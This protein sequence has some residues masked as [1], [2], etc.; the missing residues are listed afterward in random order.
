[1]FDFTYIYFHLIYFFFKRAKKKY[2]WNKTAD[3]TFI[4]VVISNDI[5]DIGNLED[6]L[7]KKC[8][9]LKVASNGG[10]RTRNINQKKMFYR[11]FISLYR[12]SLPDKCCN[13][14]YFFNNQVKYC[15]SVR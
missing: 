8:G 14:V 9:N 12:S 2:V 6:L 4:K 11:R 7:D 10:E 15:E 5:D 13:R 1:M 3:T